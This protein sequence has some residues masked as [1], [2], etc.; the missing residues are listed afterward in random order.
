MNKNDRIDVVKTFMFDTLIGTI[1]FIFIF[2]VSITLSE[3]L[4]WATKEYI[5]AQEALY[6]ATGI[7][8]L[9]LASECYLY[10]KFLFLQTQYALEHMDKSYKGVK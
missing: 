8:Y 7:K 10:I 2:G 9:I 6:L 5:H 4:H 1:L 3:V